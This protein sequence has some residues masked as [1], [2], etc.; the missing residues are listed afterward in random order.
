MLPT[1]QIEGPTQH[2]GGFKVTSAKGAN[3]TREPQHMQILSIELHINTRGKLYP[4]P[5]Q[6]PVVAL[7]YC[8]KSETDGIDFNGTP[9]DDSGV[10]DRHVGVV[11]VGEDHLRRELGT[12]GYVV[13]TVE[14]EWDLLQWLVDKVQRV[15][16]PECLTGYEVKKGS[17]GY[18]VD[19]AKAE[20]DYDLVDEL[21]RIPTQRAR[22]PYPGQ[23]SLKFVGRHVLPI[24]SLLRVDNKLQQY[25]FE[26]VAYHILRVRTPHFSHETLTKWWT[27]KYKFKRADVFKYWFKR[28]QLNIDLLDESEII[29]QAR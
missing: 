13:E 14:S 27:S 16:D 10:S 12:T 3:V 20:H 21:S 15:W 19:R 7:F 18:L 22:R 26:H 23:S 24:W 29:A 11:I 4:N 28:V 1:R 17:L 8:L 9:T 25:S 6:D 5:A 2:N